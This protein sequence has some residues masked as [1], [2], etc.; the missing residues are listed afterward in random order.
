[1]LIADA[2]PMTAEDR[3][4]CPDECRRVSGKAS[5]GTEAGVAASWVETDIVNQ[6]GGL[7]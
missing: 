7:R 2:P 1:M 4:I 3:R 5:A 6:R